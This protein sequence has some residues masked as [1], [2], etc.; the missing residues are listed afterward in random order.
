M[1]MQYLRTV[2]SGCWGRSRASRPVDLTLVRTSRAK[3]N[4]RPSRNVPISGAMEWH[5]SCSWGW[6]W[7]ANATQSS[8]TSAVPRHS[9][10]IATNERRGPGSRQ[11]GRAR[12][13]HVTSNPI[14][15]WLTSLGSRLLRHG[16]AAAA[17][18]CQVK[19]WVLLDGA[20]YPSSRSGQVRH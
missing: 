15:S 12:R 1:A 8:P 16:G 10:S 7:T 17:N 11:V 14:D 9:C 2:N 5:Q 3:L 18:C 13:R 19:Y 20:E 4:M 6:A